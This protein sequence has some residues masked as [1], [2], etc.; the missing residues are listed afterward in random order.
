MNI[1]PINSRL[2]VSI[3]IQLHFD[4]PVEYH[5]P[6]DDVRYQADTLG[7]EVVVEAHGL[8]IDSAYAK[9]TPFPFAYVQEDVQAEIRAAVY[10]EASTFVP[11]LRM[12]ALLLE[13]DTTK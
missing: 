4:Y 9:G 1:T 2:E 12:R 8:R 11:L 13:E 3:R 6:R 10:A 5:V 7:F